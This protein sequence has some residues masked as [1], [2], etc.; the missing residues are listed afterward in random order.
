MSV[1]LD[2]IGS[3][4]VAAAVILFGLRLNSNISDHLQASVATLN[5]QEGLVDA[6][7]S[8]ET[9]FRKIGYGVVDPKTAID[10]SQPGCIRFKADIDRNGTVDE[11]SWFL[12][13]NPTAGGDT[14]NYIYRQIN[15]D[16]PLLVVTDVREF[17]L[18]YLKE[19]GTPADTTVKSQIWIVE[20][21]MRVKSPYK[22]ADQ[23]KGNEVM[24]EVEGFWR[25][26]RLASRNLKRHG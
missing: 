24:N 26:T 10:I 22:V 9:D 13:Q 23:V 15:S 4:V 6:V 17:T 16:S 1:V 7:R 19:D 12:V 3:L 18:R 20:T 11:V 5:V 8:I 21:T 25:Q 2:L 14:S